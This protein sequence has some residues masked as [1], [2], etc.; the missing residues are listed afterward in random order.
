M[1]CVGQKVHPGFS[2]TSYGQPSIWMDGWMDGQR[3]ILS[4]AQPPP[5]LMRLERNLNWY[6]KP[7]N[8]RFLPT[9]MPVQP[10]HPRP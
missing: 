1:C 9:G 10:K 6:P 3:G 2:I 8:P 7:R 4:T 5:P